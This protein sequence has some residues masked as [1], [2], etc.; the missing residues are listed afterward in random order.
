METYCGNM[1]DP[2]TGAHSKGNAIIG[3]LLHNNMTLIPFAI[4]PFGH[5]GPLLCTFLF[6]TTPTTPLTFPAMQPNVAEMYH[7]ITTFPSPTGIFT[8]TR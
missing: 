6:G 2:I 7:H 8:T 1:R 5:L 3:D 4:D